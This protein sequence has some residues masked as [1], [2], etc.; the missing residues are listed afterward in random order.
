MLVSSRGETRGALDEALLKHGRSRRVAVVVPS[1]LLA[2]QLLD[3]SD[4]IAMLP[5]RSIDAASRKRLAVF[6]PP[7]AVEGFAMHIAWHARSDD[8]IAVGHV[9][10][11]LRHEL[12]GA[13]A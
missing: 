12:L 3:H 9:A 4:C 7:I 11:A 6:E 2:T 10:Q 5:R 1:F 13:G 8:D